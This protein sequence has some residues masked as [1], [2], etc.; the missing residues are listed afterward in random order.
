MRG[1]LK[2]DQQTF[3]IPFKR[4]VQMM[5]FIDGTFLNTYIWKSLSKR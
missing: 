1:C 5:E 3:S 4:F 2:P